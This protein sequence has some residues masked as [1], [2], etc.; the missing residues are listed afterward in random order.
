MLFLGMSKTE[1]T[2]YRLHFHFNF[3]GESFGHEKF[4]VLQLLSQVAGKQI[5]CP[6]HPHLLFFFGPTPS[7]L[8]YGARLMKLSAI[9]KC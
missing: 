9:P 4:V 3:V 8:C 2:F 1:H 5:L 6:T 7:R